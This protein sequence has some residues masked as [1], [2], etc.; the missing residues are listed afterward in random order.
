MGWRGV[1]NG[2]LLTLAESHGFDVFL[3]ADK[4]LAYQQNL[5]R[6]KI[7]V[8]SLSANNWPIIRNKG[9]AILAGI[10]VASP[11]SITRVDVGSFMR[12]RHRPPAP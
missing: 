12:A 6:R 1:K 9:V 5:I 8:V 4:A 11:G 7:A 10:E 2:E 3:T